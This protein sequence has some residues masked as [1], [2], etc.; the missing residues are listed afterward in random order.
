MQGVDSPGPLVIGCQLVDQRRIQLLPLFDGHANHVDGGAASLVVGDNPGNRRR[1]DE[2][3]EGHSHQ[4]RSDTGHCALL[5]KLMTLSIRCASRADWMQ[6]GRHSMV[7][8][9]RAACCSMRIRLK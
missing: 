1:A 6:K 2:Y 4:E 5:E 9:R 7:T 3:P 8:P